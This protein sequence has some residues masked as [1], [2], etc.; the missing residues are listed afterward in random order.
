[1]DATFAEA[2]QECSVPSD[3]ASTVLSAFSV[4]TF[5]RVASTRESSE[6]VFAELLVNEGHLD[7]APASERIQ[8][9]A[10]LRLLFNRCS[11]EQLSSLEAPLAPDT[12]LPAAASTAPHAAGLG[13]HESWPAK[14]T[15][16][17]VAKLREDFESS[18]PTELLDQDS[19]PSSRLLALASRI[20]T[21]KEVRWIPWNSRAQDDHLLLRPKKTP[22]LSELSDL[23]L[24]EAPTR[25]IHSGPVSH[26]LLSQLL[27]L[28]AV[29][30]SVPLGIHQDLQQKVH[31][32]VLP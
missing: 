5:A 29:A 15:T 19:F 30:Q 1:M 26:N 10:S 4:A 25:E 21:S 28:K 13:W 7:S 18:Y 6:A 12:G 31:P 9:L 24:D 17:A 32:L 11:E 27:S 14:L 16:E 23:L 22:R 2:A 3:F 8:A 20:Q